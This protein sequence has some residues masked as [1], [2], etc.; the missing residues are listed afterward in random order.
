M[1]Q[2]IDIDNWER[3]ENYLFF[4]DFTNPYYTV[5]SFVDVSN[6]YA[7]S[8]Q[9]NIKFSQ[10]AMYASLKAV[11]E[12]EPLR[13][14]Q[15]EG[16]VWLFDS[17]RLNTAVSLPDHSFISVIVPYKPSLK[18]FVASI[19]EQID[20]AQKGLG[21]AY[22]LDSEKDVVVISVNPWYSFT[23]MQFQFP[24][25]AGENMPLS[26]FGK[27]TEENGVKK[28]PVAMSFHHG[29]VDGYYVGQYWEKF[30]QNLDSF[31]HR[32]Q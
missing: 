30:Q 32:V 27:I 22:S 1:R 17:I 23:G 20:L 28:M 5:T 3:K 4:K 8:K 2:K 14:R 10:L 25:N 18:E 13:Y 12:I 24:K 7:A 9:L 29:F 16:K 21:D 19:Q 26:I 6:A 15:I 11:N 31:Y